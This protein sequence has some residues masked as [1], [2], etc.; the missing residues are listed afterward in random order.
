MFHVRYVSAQPSCAWFTM[1]KISLPR[2]RHH[3]ILS[4]HKALNPRFHRPT[5]APSRPSAS[6]SPASLSTLASRSPCF[7]KGST[8]PVG[9][10]PPNLDRMAS[11]PRSP[12]RSNSEKSS[13]SKSPSLPLAAYPLKVRAISV[14]FTQGLRYGFEFLTLT[15][16][17]RDTVQR[18]CQ[19]LPSNLDPL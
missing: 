11:A 8:A 4:Q 7:S 18:V 2:R 19:Y 12:A 9:D 3:K 16:S 5:A 17:Q 13:P 14:R 1:K 10:A 6:L 15:A